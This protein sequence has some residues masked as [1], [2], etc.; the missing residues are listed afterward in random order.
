MVDL[1]ARRRSVVQAA[2]VGQN[3]AARVVD[4]DGRG[5]VGAPTPEAFSVT[6]DYAL[7][8]PLQV[9]VERGLELVRTFEP[10]IVEQAVH[11]MRCLERMTHGGQ[12]NMAGERSVEFGLAQETVLRECR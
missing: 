8:V 11:E 1:A 12:L 6:L 3:L 7:D 5:V 2:D 4:H 10:W 9:E